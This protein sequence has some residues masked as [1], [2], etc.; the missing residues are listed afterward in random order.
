MTDTHAY[1]PYVPQYKQM[2]VEPFQYPP[3]QLP[4]GT[5]AVA[6]KEKAPFVAQFAPKRRAPQ[7]VAPQHNVPY[8]ETITTAPSI[9][10][11]N[12]GNNI[13]TGWTLPN[14]LSTQHSFVT[15]DTVESMDNRS[16]IDNNDYVSAPYYP[17]P[18]WQPDPIPAY[19]PRAPQ[20]T[21]RPPVKIEAP[22]PAQEQT[23]P[24]LGEYMLIVGGNIILIGA[25]DVIQARAFE[26]LTDEQTPASPEDIII[27]KRVDF[28]VGVSLTE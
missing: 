13:E 20:P 21:F 27:L 25:R 5:Q 19:P 4:A 26:I 14:G 10:A 9:P 12:V 8:A 3:R 7:T 22:P 24:N 23:V 17:A 16:M 6:A 11:M 1:K 15:A 18:Q 2:G 28:N